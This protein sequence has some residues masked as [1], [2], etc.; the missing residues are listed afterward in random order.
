MMIVGYDHNILGHF[1]AITKEPDFIHRAITATHSH[2]GSAV[3]LHA[4]WIGLLRFEDVRDLFEASCDSRIH[5]LN[6]Y[7]A[8]RGFLVYRMV[9]APRFGLMETSSASRAARLNKR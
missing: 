8:I 6:N 3:S 7:S 5:L 9:S 4:I 2:G 1:T